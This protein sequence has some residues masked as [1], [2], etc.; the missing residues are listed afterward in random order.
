MLREVPGLTTTEEMTTQPTT[1]TTTTSDLHD[2]IFG[3][4]PNSP[5]LEAQNISNNN[6]DIPSTAQVLNTANTER[7]DIPRLRSTHVTAGYR[8]GISVSKA[9]HVQRGFDEGFSLGAVLGLKAGFLNGVFEG[10]VRAV[11]SS[12]GI[13]VGVREE[14]IKQF[15]ACREELA[16]QNLF[17]A[18]YFGQDGIWKYEVGDEGEDEEVT[19]G[20]VADGHPVVRKWAEEVEGLKKRFGFEIVERTRTDGDEEDETAS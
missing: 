2:D 3:S 10:V 12:G 14:V 11:S 16:L 20:V 19:F 4:A 9:E 6:D 17:S 15:L 18:E 1:T 13:D 8:D 7:S 5:E